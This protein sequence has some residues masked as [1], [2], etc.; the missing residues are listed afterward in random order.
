MLGTENMITFKQNLEMRKFG[1]WPVVRHF[2]GLCD[3]QI[4]IITI[5][6]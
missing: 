3:I 6:A 2:V 1:N 5:E 4:R